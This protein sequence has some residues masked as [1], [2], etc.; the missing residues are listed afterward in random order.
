MR[1]L[2]SFPLGLL[3]I[4]SAPVWS[5]EPVP[6][7]VVRVGYQS[8]SQETI[9]DGV[10]EAVKEGTVTAQTS[11][12]VTEVN[13]DVNDYVTKGSVLVR[14]RATEQQARLDQADAAVREAEAR[15]R[16]AQLEYDRLRGMVA[17]KLVAQAAFD[18]AEAELKAARARLGAARAQLAQA[19]EQLNYTIVRAPY[20]GIVTKR[21]IEPGET[22]QVGQPLMTG[23]SLEQMRVHVDLPQTYVDD[24]RRHRAA[25]VLLPDNRTVQPTD[26]TIF[27][28][29]DVAS[30]TFRVRLDLLADVAGVY[31]GMFVKVA[32]ATGSMRALLV[33]HE[34]V[35]FRSEVTAVYVVDAA[36]RVVM[37]QVRLGK[38]VGEAVVVLAGLQE[39]EQVVRDP[40]R[41][42]AAL[43][44][45]AEAR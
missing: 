8:V 29:A 23:L 16:D 28:Y 27:P 38:R 41:A 35:A 6:L 17:E 18:R 9:L 14:L 1:S 2:R 40:I 22:A 10:I 19:Q 12:R 33:P 37:R 13:F 24:V 7:E 45:Q 43:K 5:A 15:N 20:N 3:F 42:A 26:V 21:P 32:F 4:M 30:H 39:G 34:A 36:G 31:P 25:R 44:R 11:G